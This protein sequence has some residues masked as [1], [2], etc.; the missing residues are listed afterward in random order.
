M[1]GKVR[2]VFH[3][4][5]SQLDVTL[6]TQ[7]NWFNTFNTSSAVASKIVTWPTDGN[8][9]SLKA[10]LRTIK[11][12]TSNLSIAYYLD[13]VLQATHVAANFYGKAMWL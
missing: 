12:S 8:F 11:G 3:L 13:N 7:Q 5:S 10:V 4:A 6:G 1:N 9:H 2:S